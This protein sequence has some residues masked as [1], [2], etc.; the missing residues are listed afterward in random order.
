MWLRSWEQ[1][2]AGWR[3]PPLL[4]WAER[5]GRG[6]ATHWGEGG[7]WPAPHSF[8][9]RAECGLWAQPGLRLGTVHPGMCCET[10]MPSRSPSC[11][12]R[13]SDEGLGVAKRRRSLSGSAS[14]SP[15]SR[16][17]PGRSPRAPG[18]QRA[19]ALSR[20]GRWAPSSRARHFPAA[21]PWDPLLNLSV[22]R[23]LFCE[24]E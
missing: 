22:L 24:S 18:W 23:F 2:E 1:I 15:E 14:R 4:G 11:P 8:R 20:A 21:R 7:P 16:R 3:P 17:S 10:H 12:L 9:A 5:E 6:A 19:E 13:F